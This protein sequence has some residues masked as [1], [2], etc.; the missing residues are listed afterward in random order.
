MFSPERRAVG[1]A[2][3]G[4]WRSGLGSEESMKCAK[5]VP[6][7]RTAQ[8]GGDHASVVSVAALEDFAAQCARL[9]SVRG[10]AITRSASDESH[11][12]VAGSG[13]PLAFVQGAP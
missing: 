11:H 7:H 3:F 2:L 6:L 8:Y 12:D 1:G 5:S 4:V 9:S 13:A 10:R